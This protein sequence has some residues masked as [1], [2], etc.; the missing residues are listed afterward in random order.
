MLAING[1]YDGTR[2]TP[3]DTVNALPNQKV[4]I[5]FTEEFAEPHESATRRDLRGALSK[6]ADP[7]AAKT[8]KTAW[9][10]EAARKH[11]DI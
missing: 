10:R 9:A 5:T 7:E 3:L 11:G 4:I 6:Y 8:E 2:I 1:F